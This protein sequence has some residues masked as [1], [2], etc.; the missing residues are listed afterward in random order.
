MIRYNQI[1][2]LTAIC[3]GALP[4]MQCSFAQEVEKGGEGWQVNK[5]YRNEVELT[6]DS[7]VFK[8]VQ[9]LEEDSHVFLRVKAPEKTNSEN[10]E[11]AFIPPE[12]EVVPMT[13]FDILPTEEIAIQGNLAPT[14]STFNNNDNDFVGSTKRTIPDF[15]PGDEDEPITDLIWWPSHVDRP[16][17]EDNSVE[18]ATA[19][20]LLHM[21]LIASPRI[22][23]I[24]KDPLIREAQIIEADAEFDPTVF[25]RNLFEDRTDPV[26]NT[27]TT[28][29]AEFLRDHIFTSDTGIRKKLRTGADLEI[30]QRL[31]FQNSN[32]QFFI[33]QD[34]GTATLAINVSQPLLKGGGKY[35]NR[36]QILLAQSAGEVAW[37]V[38]S[39]EL[40]DELQ[41]VLSAYW[42]LYFDRS[43]YL[44][45][46]RNV[47][48]GQRILD[49]LIQRSDLD[50]LPSQIARA[51]SA[52][53]ARKTDLA[54]AF[55][56]VRNAETNIRRF[57]GDDNWLAKQ[58]V[59]ILPIERPTMQDLDIPLQKVVYTALENRPEIR[60]AANRTK[61][62][63]LQKDISTNELLP[64]LSLLMGTYVSGLEGDSGIERAWVEQF[65]NTTPG[66]SMVWSLRYRIEI[67]RLEADLNKA[68]FNFRNSIM[69]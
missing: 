20:G 42:Q 2:I 29:G 51:K 17:D 60:E 24:S 27:L 10:K 33:P 3:V 39:S 41:R 59:E 55:R 57:V 49:T 11:N 46:Q 21:S 22:Q 48:R 50:S 45:K 37:E 30:S 14:P 53:Q 63:A 68:N 36:L 13:P 26:G 47:E 28:G 65:S 23:A 8:Q 35:Y 62:A 7:I 15:S 4:L 6:T 12:K 31:G 64:D 1:F 18:T 52:V 16:F 40:Q 9:H 43:N 56:N 19:D 5:T 44:Q 66:Y 58:A 32:S 38:F 25:T 54:N 61:I 67:E 69:N 34:Q